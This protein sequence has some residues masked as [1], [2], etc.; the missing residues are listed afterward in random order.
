MVDDS[1][2]SW[3]ASKAV[4]LAVKW[5]VQMAASLVSNGVVLRVEMMVDEKVACLVGHLV[6]VLDVTTVV[7]MVAVMV[8]LSAVDLADCS[9]A[10]MAVLM[11]VPMVALYPRRVRKKW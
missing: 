9:D 7:E 6:H 11:V 8:A 4:Y 10:S 5:V 2:E 3:D 1:V